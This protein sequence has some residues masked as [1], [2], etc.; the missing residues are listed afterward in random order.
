MQSTP[1]GAPGS[2]S[3][4]RFHPL[5]AQDRSAMAAALAVGST[6]TAFPASS[7]YTPAERAGL[8]LKAGGEPQ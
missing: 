5:T 1:T 8:F 3:W 2:E 6:L 4:F 7:Q